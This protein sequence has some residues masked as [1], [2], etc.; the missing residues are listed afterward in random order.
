MPLH[1][2]YIDDSG[3]KE[4]ANNPNDYGSNNSRHFVFGGVLLTVDNSGKLSDKII[5]EKIKTF[6]TEA[7]E[8]K[9]NWLRIPKERNKRYLEVFGISEED[10]DIF[11]ENF[12]QAVIDTDLLLIGAIVDKA[13]MQ[14]VYQRPYYPPSIAYEILLQRVEN[15]LGGRGDV[16][17]IIDDMTGKTPKGNDYKINLLKQ[18]ER[19]KK[20]GSQLLDGFTFN[21]ISGR[22]KFTNS[23][24]SHMIQVA[25][26]VSYNLHRQFRDY[27]LEW[28][29]ESLR[30]LPTYEQFN[31]I[32][33]KFRMGPNGEIQ[34]YGVV[35]FPISHR[36]WWA[37]RK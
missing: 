24:H 22:L 11:V 30:E 13:E 27:G 21:C 34:G 28:E 35:K 32:G 8:I 4:Y 6:G 3:T 29:D 31:R 16:S 25:D 1:V 5:R 23:A 37:Y 7:V 33:R 9:S 12:Y 2:L 36:I 14:Q 10:I 19:L 20:K 15:E 18:H 17:V 26:I